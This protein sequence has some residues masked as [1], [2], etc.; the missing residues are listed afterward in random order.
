MQGPPWVGIPPIR[1]L[2]LHARYYELMGIKELPEAELARCLMESDGLFGRLRHLKPVVQL[3]E[4]APFYAK[5]PE[6]LGT[7]QACWA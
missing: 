4:T 5:A 3:S 1:V 2:H 6:P 7:S